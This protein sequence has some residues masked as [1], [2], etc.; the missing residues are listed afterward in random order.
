MERHA[1]ADNLS[2]ISWSDRNLKDKCAEE[3][4]T[5]YYIFN[6]PQIEKCTEEGITSHILT[7]HKLI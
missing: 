4:I 6:Q 5:S 3:G 7:N 1:M 2:E